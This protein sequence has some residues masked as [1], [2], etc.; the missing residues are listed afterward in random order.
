MRLINPNWNRQITLEENKVP[1]I[2]VENKYMFRDILL[3]LRNQIEGKDGYLLFD[4]L[5][6]TIKISKHIELI[7]DYIHIDLN[8][9]KILTKLYNNLKIKAIEEY[10]EYSSIVDK[11]SEYIQTL[12]SDEELELVQLK[13]IEPIDLFKGVSLEIEDNNLTEMERLI[14]YIVLME[15]IVGIKVF[16][17]VNLKLFFSENEINLFYDTL[18]NKKIQFVLIESSAIKSINSREKLYIYDEDCCEI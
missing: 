8:D 11:V 7:L 12:I 14:E 3:D 4:D 10:Q 1:I 15:N 13:N 5:K 6:D 9:K 17:L 16:I 18:I 2:V